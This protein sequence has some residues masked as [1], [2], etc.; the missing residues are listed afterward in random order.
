[1]D[2][3]EVAVNY[4]NTTINN[5]N[6]IKT[7]DESTSHSLMEVDND[8][9]LGDID[10]KLQHGTLKMKEETISSST[11]S[12]DNSNSDIS[13]VVSKA[14]RA[15]DSLWIIL[16]AQNCRRYNC[17]RGCYESKHILLHIKTCKTTGD[18]NNFTCPHNFKGCSQ[19]KRLLAHY[20]RCRSTRH[21]QKQSPCLICSFLSRHARN[22]VEGSSSNHDTTT[23][24]SFHTKSAPLSP[25]SN[26]SG[27]SRVMKY[28]T[29]NNE[30]RTM[31]TNTTSSE[32]SS[33]SIIMPPPPPRIPLKSCLRGERKERTVSFSI[34][35][36]KKRSLSDESDKPLS[37]ADRRKRSASLDESRSPSS[38]CIAVK[39][40]DPTLEMILTREVVVVQQS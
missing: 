7:N 29:T 40:N 13:L 5:D 1:M 37:G 16:H 8:S 20:H 4:N 38:S 3:K 36:G 27:S 17:T 31:T 30:N 18:T 23:V 2:Q 35:E 22:F 25:I 19:A 6:K 33:S 21:I 32:E 11:N 12:V 34:R 15:A 14:K 28:G 26:S 24:S 9:S 39:S 10:K